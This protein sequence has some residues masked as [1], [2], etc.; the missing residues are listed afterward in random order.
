MAATINKDKGWAWVVLIASA[1]S[2][3]IFVVL[4]ASI[5][6]FQVEIMED[7]G[8]GSGPI[9]IMSA[10][11]L[12]QSC[13]LGPVSGVLS[14]LLSVRVT[15]YLGVSL[16]SGGLVLASFSQS[17]PTLTFFFGFLTGRSGKL[18]PFAD[19]CYFRLEYKNKT[20]SDLE[21]LTQPASS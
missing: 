8:V 1:A 20:D 3:F 17:L 6:F 11:A 4:S 21:S 18:V 15:V 12:G 7:L 9:S 13:V 14:S 2:L 19:N 5:G 16:Y 10:L